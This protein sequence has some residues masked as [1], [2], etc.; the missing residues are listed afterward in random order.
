MLEAI[1]HDDVQLA[2]DIVFPRDGWLATRASPDAAKE[3][4]KKVEG[5]FRRA[6]HRL[7][8]HHQDFDRA[9]LVSVELGHA[10]TQET[11]R[12]RGW[13]KALWTVH[14]SRITFVVEGRTRT[15]TI[16]E[17]TAWRGAWYV[18]RLR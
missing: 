10:M 15:L 17:M 8:K 7:S 3:W 1:A 2:T 18:S 13:K 16:R 6:V 11:P 5:P 12:P 14:A 4:D 9:Q